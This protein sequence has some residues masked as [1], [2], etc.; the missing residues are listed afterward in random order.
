MSFAEKLR[1]VRM[2]SG[3]TQESLGMILNVSRQ[4]ITKWENGDSYPDVDNLLLL[5]S[6]LGTSLDSLFEDELEVK[7]GEKDSDLSLEADSLLETG[8]IQKEQFEDDAERILNEI[9][10]TTDIGDT[11]SSGNKIVDFKDGGFRRRRVY[12]LAGPAKIG[13][14]AFALSVANRIAEKGKVIWYS[15]ADTKK[16]LYARILASEAGVP[17]TRRYVSGYSNKKREQLKSAVQRIS[18]KRLA[19]NEMFQGN[20]DKIREELCHETE[21]AD[22]IVID[23]IHE[24]KIGDL[25]KTKVNLNRIAMENNCPVLIIDRTSS[26]EFG[27]EP[28]I[29]VSCMIK[30]WMPYLMILNRRD[31]YDIKY[32]RDDGISLC[33][34]NIYDEELN[35]I[36]KG[37][38]LYC[39]ELCRF[40]D[41]M[42]E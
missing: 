3:L 27:V 41:N 4:S 26:E 17:T 30:G 38:L 39:P 23:G 12:I 34:L 21:Q 13:K 31:Y 29:Y 2:N 32:R 37:E 35:L 5:S 22:L 19:I 14:T 20:I 24:I 7:K 16:D 42:E 10:N 15:C 40:E 9:I 8:L 11:V 25:R 28:Q 18:Q 33:N 1:A 36:N 6:K